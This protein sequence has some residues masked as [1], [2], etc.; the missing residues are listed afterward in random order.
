MKKKDILDERAREIRRK[1]GLSQK[2]LGKLV[3]VRAGY[4]SQLEN[5]YVFLK[6]ELWKKIKK[7]LNEALKKRDEESLDTVFYFSPRVLGV[8]IIC[9]PEKII[10]SFFL[11]EQ[12][13]KVLKTLSF[14]EEKVLRLRFGLEDGYPH[15][16][17]EVAE[18]F[19]VTR[20]RIRQIETKALRKL[21]YPTRS[22]KLRDFLKE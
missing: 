12:L 6:P 13:K 1:L 11:G 20:E 3:N 9:N 16:L 7:V 22:R 8:K 5:G 10:D 21:R 4:I 19:S 14:R 17:E 2:S 18:K 15:A